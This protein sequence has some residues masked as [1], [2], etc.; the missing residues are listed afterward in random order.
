MLTFSG[1]RV[2]LYAAAGI[3]ASI[4]IACSSSGAEDA[5]AVRPPKSSRRQPSPRLHRRQ[6]H[7]TRKTPTPDH[8]ETHS[9]RHDR[10]ADQER[11]APGTRRRR[12]E[13]RY[14]LIRPGAKGQSVH[15]AFGS[16]QRRHPVHR[17]ARIRDRQFCPGLS[18]A[19][20]TRD[21]DQH[22]RRRSGV[23]ALNPHVARNRQ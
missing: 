4:T 10:R 6:N 3:V 2:S 18:P 21:T 13:L 17:H 5:V 7:P 1:T 11:L 22:Q 20:R 23:P 16:R 15:K 9:G 8:S 14:H 12:M 19:G